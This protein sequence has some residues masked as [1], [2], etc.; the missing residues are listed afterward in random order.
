MKVIAERLGYFTSL[1]PSSS[2]LATRQE[3][4]ARRR[5]PGKLQRSGE[6]PRLQQC[7]RLFNPCMF[8]SSCK[9]FEF[10]LREPNG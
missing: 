6:A 1:P 8:K 9:A 2:G 5:S 10:R 4:C 3:V 7:K